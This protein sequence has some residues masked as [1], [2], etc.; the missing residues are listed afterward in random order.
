MVLLGR[1]ELVILS[2]VLALAHPAAPAEPGQPSGA[3]EASLVE[4]DTLTL[5]WFGAGPRLRER[6][7]DISASLTQFYQGLV[8]GDG[9]DDWEYGGKQDVF[10]RLDGGKLGLWQGLRISAH[11]EQTFG[12]SNQAA[13]GTLLPSNTAMKFPRGN[14]S[15]CDLSLYGTQQIGDRVTVSFGKINMLNMYAAGHEFSGGRGIESFEHLEFVGPISGITP[16]MMFG[17]IISVHTDPAKFT[18]MIYDP[19]DRTRQSGFADAFEKGVTFQGSVQFGSDFFGRSGRHIISAAYSTQ[20]GVDFEDIPELLIPGGG[21]AD[22]TDHR[23]YL[24]Y[25]VEQTLWRDPARPINAW[26]LFAR[27]SLSDGNPNP[28]EWSAL[29]G[30]GGTSPIPGRDR[31]RFGVGVFY[32]GFSDELKEGL[33]PLLPLRDEYGAE[34]FYNFAV[35]PWFRL[36]ADLQ[37]IRPGL[38]GQDPAV[39]AGVRAQIVF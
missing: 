33:R 27:V 10:F 22:E 30:I 14:E 16:P 3:A 7:I 36:T 31:D 12:H 2:V 35:T 28:V 38:D 5:D 4:R 37:V 6:G 26:G 19:A 18:L 15:V 24:A 17:G 34:I 32:V 21:P 39:I 20:D 25:D 9:P 23:W 29:G 1:A 11:F 13:G 8:S